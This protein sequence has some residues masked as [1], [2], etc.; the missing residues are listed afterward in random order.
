MKKVQAL[1]DEVEQDINAKKA[2]EIRKEHARQAQALTDEAERLRRSTEALNDPKKFA[3]TAEAAQPLHEIHRRAET[4]PADALFNGSQ[5][6][7]IAGPMVARVLLSNIT[8]VTL[9]Y[10][11]SRDIARQK[12]LDTNAKKLAEVVAALERL[13]QSLD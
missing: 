13:E 5:S 3:W 8:H 6:M 12:A 11:Q 4:L 7:G 2:A 9:G 1:L 10:V